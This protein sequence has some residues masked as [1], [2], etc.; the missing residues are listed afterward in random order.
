MANA[1]PGWYAAQGDPPGT[2]RWWDGAQWIGQ[3]QVQPTVGASAPQM[4]GGFPAAPPQM[5][6]DTSGQHDA[7]RGPFQWYLLALKRWKTFDG[8][9]RRS[10]YWWFTLITAGISF[11]LYI[12]L[13]AMASADSGGDPSPLTFV[14]LALL[15]LFALAMF[16]PGL[17]VAVRRLHDTNRSGWYY[18][19]NLV[20]C[21]SL[22]LLVF[23]FLDS[24]PGP[25]RYGM[26]PKGLNPLGQQFR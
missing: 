18:L 9:S 13:I 21:I 14:F 24:T 26:N 19:L 20:P 5:V 11:V 2:V 12:P 6:Y 3:P 23:F 25:N 7:D 10:E 17:A 15:V 22:V 16:I 8:R 4:A 1:Q